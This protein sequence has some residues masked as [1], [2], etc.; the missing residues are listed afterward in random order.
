MRRRKLFVGLLTILLIG[1]VWFANIG[2]WLDE[3][4][5]PQKADLI[6][7][8]GGGAGYRV[9]KTLELYRQ[10]ND[11][12][13]MVIVT[14]HRFIPH[15]STAVFDVKDK[16][17][18]L[19]RGGVDADAI[20]HMPTLKNTMQEMRAVKEFM[21][22][23]DMKSV[24]FVSN[25]YHSSRIKYL[26]NTLNH[27]KNEGLTAMVVASDAPW[28]RTRHSYANL[29]SFQ[30]A[31]QETLKYPYNALKYGLLYSLFNSTEYLRK[32]KGPL[33]ALENRLKRVISFV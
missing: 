17:T 7:C 2:A 23:H 13:G 27:Y 10:G 11:K 15:N 33:L 18:Y 12:S 3:T 1:T 31:F 19:E 29:E 8:L 6:V 22:T 14:S 21:K 30:Y 28:A 16:I 26:A 4:D 32:L 25:F 9:K 5:K 20:V 24:I